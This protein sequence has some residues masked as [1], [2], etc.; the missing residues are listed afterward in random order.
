[1]S[2]Q[3]GI[4]L[5]GTFFKTKEGAERYAEEKRSFPPYP[6]FISLCCTDGFLVVF[7]NQLSKAST[8]TLRE[9]NEPENNTPG[10]PE[11][12]EKKEVDVDNIPF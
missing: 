4:Y 11:S 10:A 8:N 2:D 7:S 12:P 5:V 1:M 6:R 9:E 3:T